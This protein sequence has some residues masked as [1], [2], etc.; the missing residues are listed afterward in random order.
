MWARRQPVIRGSFLITSMRHFKFQIPDEPIPVEN[1]NARGV[2]EVFGGKADYLKRRSIASQASS[3]ARDNTP[4]KPLPGRAT[5][6]AT[7]YTVDRSTVFEEWRHTAP[8]PVG[9]H[10]SKLGSAMCK[11]KYDI[12]E[13]NDALQLQIIKGCNVFEVDCSCTDVKFAETALAFQE[14][15]SAFELD[16]DG[17][18]MVV[19]CGLLYDDKRKSEV[20]EPSFANTSAVRNR[21]YPVLQRMLAASFPQHSMNSGFKLAEMTDEQCAAVNLRRATEKFAI[22]L[23]PSWIEG[24]LIDVATHFKLETVD[25]MLLQGIE[26]L[27]DGRDE[28]EVELDIY[29]CFAFLEA[30]VDHGVLQ[31][32]GVSSPN[33]APPIPR[34]DP[35]LPQDAKIPEKY[36]NPKRNKTVLNLYKLQAIAKRVAGENHHFRFAEYPI[37]F[38]QHQAMSSVLPYDGNHTI[39]TLCKSLGMT[40]LG[41][42]PLETTDLQGHCQRYH[43]FPLDSDLKSLRMNFF[44]ALERVMMKEMEVQKSIENGPPT[45]PKPQEIFVGSVYV[46][47]QRQLSNFFQFCDWMDFKLIPAFRKSMARLKEASPANM[48]EWCSNYDQMFDDAMKMR[49]RLFEH[50]HGVKAASM[51]MYVDVASPTLGQC[52]LLSQKA[53]N[54]AAQGC[55]VLLCGFHVARYFHEATELNP[56]KNQRIPLAE[57]DA[58][59]QSPDVSFANYNPPDPYMLEVISATG[60]FSQQKGRGLENTIAID[61]NDPKFPDIPDEIQ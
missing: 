37:N 32:Y 17:F 47:V 23:S 60:R 36:R 34:V 30:Q 1:P 45:L 19:R 55:D 9:W 52:P 28:E 57:L 33:L 10:M 29:K 54:F 53:I 50:K 56:I 39:Q 6:D 58:L 13:S 61:L 35:P 22:A 41:I 38:T 24:A 14:T 27:Y 16:R 21:M 3:E 42:T 59:Y 48:K 5:P 51:N 15:L 46:A 43:M 8:A 2:N 18:V 40:S 26:Y 11:Y 44:A 31:Y 20:A 12:F 7:K 49:R 4:L 25:V